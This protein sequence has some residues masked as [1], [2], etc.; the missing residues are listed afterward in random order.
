MDIK[1]AIVLEDPTVF[2]ITRAKNNGLVPIVLFPKED[3]ITPERAKTYL[4]DIGCVARVMDNLDI[5]CINKPDPDKEQECVS[6]L[7]AEVCSILAN[8]E[9]SPLNRGLREG[10]YEPVEA[11]IPYFLNLDLM[12]DG[13][14]TNDI[15][16]MFKIDNKVSVDQAVIE[17]ITECVKLMLQDPD[18]QQLLAKDLSDSTISAVVDNVFLNLEDEIVIN[19]DRAYNVNNIEIYPEL[20]TYIKAHGK[21]LLALGIAI[22]IE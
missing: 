8:R 18:V 7:E 16:A 20:F 12:A 5:I 14:R 22:Y 19:L 21:T 2:D 3:K 17:H 13:L 4:K 9:I 11:F 10:R 15:I 1:N 6:Y